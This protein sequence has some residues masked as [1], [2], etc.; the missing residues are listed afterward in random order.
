[1]H[2]PAE[3]A[4]WCLVAICDKYVRG[5]YSAGLVRDHVSLDLYGLIVPV[6]AAANYLLSH[7]ALLMCQNM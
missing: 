5:Y 7:C 6:A 1:M 4:F 2:M 3:Q